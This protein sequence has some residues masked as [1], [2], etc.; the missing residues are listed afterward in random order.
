MIKNENM[1]VYKNYKNNYKFIY[2]TK[3]KNENNLTEIIMKLKFTLIDLIRI[4]IPY[5]YLNCQS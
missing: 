2:D 1:E 4:E 5:T 3:I